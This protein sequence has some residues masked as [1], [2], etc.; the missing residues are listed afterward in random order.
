LKLFKGEIDM[1]KI[2]F[3]SLIIVF[4][5]LINIANS[6]IYRSAKDGRKDGADDGVTGYKYVETYFWDAFVYCWDPGASVCPGEVEDE[7]GESVTPPHQSAAVDY[8]LN[9]ISSGVLTG[10]EKQGDTNIEWT[11]TDTD[12]TTSDIIVWDDGETKPTKPIGVE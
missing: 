4:F 12:A 1:K 2:N 7:N 6:A 9:Q 8:A 10:S 5:L 3:V 11:A